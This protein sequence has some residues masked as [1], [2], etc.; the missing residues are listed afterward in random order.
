MAAS[1][2]LNSGLDKHRP[3]L[4]QITK[5]HPTT[6]SVSRHQLISGHYGAGNKTS[7]PALLLQTSCQPVLHPLS[8]PPSLSGSS[9]VPC[10]HMGASGALWDCAWAGQHTGK[11]RVLWS[12]VKLFRASVAAGAFQQSTLGKRHKSHYGHPN[13]ETVSGATLGRRTQRGVS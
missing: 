13:F 4:P 8:L 3:S 10:G 12:S 11:W 9:A 2:L 1:K 5:A 6:L 7:C